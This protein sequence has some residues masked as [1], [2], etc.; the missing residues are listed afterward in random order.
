MRERSSILTGELLELSRYNGVNVPHDYFDAAM[1]RLRTRFLKQPMYG[2]IKPAPDHDQVAVQRKI[3][4]V[5]AQSMPTRKQLSA[6]D[7]FNKAMALD[8]NSDREIT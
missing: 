6:E 8:D 7:Y 4:E 1:E 5:V 3:D 2:V